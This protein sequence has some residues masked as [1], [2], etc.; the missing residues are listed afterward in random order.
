MSKSDNIQI[1]DTNARQLMARYESTTTEKAL[2]PFTHIITAYT[3]SKLALDIGS[4]SGR[5]A[6]WM[7]ERG[8]QVDA[9]DGSA[10]LLEEAQKLHSHTNI[11]YRHDLAPDFDK[12]R[13]IGKRYNAILMSA[14]IFHFDKADRDMILQVCRDMLSPEGLLYITL[15]KGPVLEGRHIFDVPVQEIEYFALENTLSV[16]YHGRTQDSAGLGD[17]AWDHISVWHGAAW[18]HAKDYSCDLAHR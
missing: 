16:H 8:W 10:A 13:D 1:Y 6:A 11:C 17:I 4:G 12:T 14:F 5:D 7:A 15:R 2:T 3:G 9:V 18:D